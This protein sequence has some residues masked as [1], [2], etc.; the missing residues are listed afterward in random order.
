MSRRP[1]DQIA[2][3]R[4]P[5]G[6]QFIWDEIQKFGG[7]PFSRAEINKATMLP[8]RTVSSYLQCLTA[9]GYLERDD[10]GETYR[11]RQLQ[12]SHHAPRLRPDGTPAA[13]QGAGTANLWRS[14][15]M[16]GQFNSRELAAHSTTE[17]VQVSEETA[18][19]YVHLLL[20]CGY[21]RVVRCAA[22]NKQ[23]Q[24]VYR[25]IRNSG[26][27][28]PQVQRVKRIYDANTGTVYYPERGA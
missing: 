9:G 4:D 10:S 6:R 26:P 11:W 2:A 12:A 25:L 1:V 28:P 3:S 21:L 15:R 8:T 17:T 22:P 7:R 18:K 23:R 20:A 14:M 5:E 13:V 19:S 27:L 24:A 16:L